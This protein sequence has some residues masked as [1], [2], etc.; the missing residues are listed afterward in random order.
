MGTIMSISLEVENR[1]IFKEQYNPL[2]SSLTTAGM[3]IAGYRALQLLDIHNYKWTILDAAYKVIEPRTFIADYKHITVQN[4]EEIISHS[5]NNIGYIVWIKHNTFHGQSYNRYIL[6][7]QSDFLQLIQG[8]ITMAAAFNIPVTDIIAYKIVHITIL[9]GRY[10]AKYFDV[11]DVALPSYNV[12]E[13]QFTAV[14]NRDK[15]IKPMD[16]RIANLTEYLNNKYRHLGPVRAATIEPILNAARTIFRYTP[17]NDDIKV[18]EIYLGYTGNN[19]GIEDIEKYLKN[20]N[21]K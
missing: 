16:E 4:P 2:L 13:E 8:I 5:C 18:I 7:G 9:D 20:F 3:I 12:T 6:E 17:E 1:V 14:C 19:R 11:N 15:L 21:Y 10:I